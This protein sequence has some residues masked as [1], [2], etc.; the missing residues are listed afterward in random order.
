[1]ELLS[2]PIGPPHPRIEHLV[3]AAALFALA[4]LVAVRLLRRTGRVRDERDERDERPDAAGIVRQRTGEQ[5]AE[6]GSAGPFVLVARAAPGALR[7][8]EHAGGAPECA[9]AEAELRMYVSELA[10]DLAH[11]LVGERVAAART[12]PRP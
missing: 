7:R 12:E 1:M 9:A 6:E 4:V 11:R 10:S 2:F 3:V 5:L 8:Q